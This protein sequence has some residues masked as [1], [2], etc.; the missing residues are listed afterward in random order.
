[1]TTFS[2]SLFYVIN[3]RLAFKS[4]KESQ[5]IEDSLPEIVPGYL[6]RID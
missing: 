6:G 2:S 5:N 3:F 4:T 1:M